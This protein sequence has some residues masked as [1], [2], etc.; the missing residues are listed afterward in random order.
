[1]APKLTKPEM[2][3]EVIDLVITAIEEERQ[4]RGSLGQPDAVRACYTLALLL[5]GD[6]MRY[7][8]VTE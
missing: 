8:G 5:E 1:M 4:L 7:F 6:L 3:K 2:G